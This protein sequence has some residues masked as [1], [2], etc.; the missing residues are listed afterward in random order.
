MVGLVILNFLNPNFAEILLVFFFL[1]LT[2]VEK[3]AVLQSTSYWVGEKTTVK[4]TTKFSLMIF[5]L[6]PEN[7]LFNL[8]LWYILRANLFF[9]KPFNAWCPP[10]GHAYQN[11]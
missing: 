11:L 5:F 1:I 10:K 8:N 3:R 2:V 6:P 7:K 4:K 9:A